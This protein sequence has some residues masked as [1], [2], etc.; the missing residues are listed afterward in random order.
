LFEVKQ[1]KA[2]THFPMYE[3]PDQMSADIDEFVGRVTGVGLAAAA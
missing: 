1:L 2:R 3:A